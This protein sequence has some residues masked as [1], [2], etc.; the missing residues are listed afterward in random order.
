MVCTGKNTFR[1]FL[2]LHNMNSGLGINVGCNVVFQN[3][4]G[5]LRV[6]SGCA[7]GVLRVCSG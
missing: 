5:V 3:A 4:Q 6:S 7:Q 2:Q 1:R